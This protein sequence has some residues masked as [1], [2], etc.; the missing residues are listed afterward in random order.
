MMTIW[1]Q[2]S[3]MSQDVLIQGSRAQRHIGASQGALQ[4]FPPGSCPR[5]AVVPRLVCSLGAR[6]FRKD[7]PGCDN[8]QSGLRT[9]P[10]A[11]CRLA[12]LCFP[13]GLR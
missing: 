2:L 7:C 1:A 6:Q 11:K 5:Y 4:I 3:R 9:V 12:A 10:Q 13:G 8:V